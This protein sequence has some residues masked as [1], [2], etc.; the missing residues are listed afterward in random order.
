MGVELIYRVAADAKVEFLPETL[1]KIV[2]TKDSLVGVYIEYKI[3]LESDFER[4]LYGG[5]FD[6]VICFA[7]RVVA[8]LVKV[9]EYELS[10]NQDFN[11]TLGFNV[12]GEPARKWSRVHYDS[13]GVK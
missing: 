13:L 9:Q 1:K 3:H 8:E 12:T 5:D 7:K 6:N 4:K 2:K 10:F 11:G